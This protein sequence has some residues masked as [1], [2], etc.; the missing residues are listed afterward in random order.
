MAHNV[1]YRYNQ[2]YYTYV[3]P[4][5]QNIST[6]ACHRKIGNRL[7]YVIVFSHTLWCWTLIM[8]SST[9]VSQ[10]HC[11][12]NNILLIKCFI[13]NH[14]IAIVSVSYSL[15]NRSLDS[16]CINHKLQRLLYRSLVKD[17]RSMGWVIW[18]MVTSQFKTDAFFQR[19][20]YQ[21]T[22]RATWEWCSN[23]ANKLFFVDYCSS[24][25]A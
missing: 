4:D 18:W 3:G 7:K 25:D 11:R 12:I 24:S 5:G 14:N 16:R 19:G 15:I 6:M 8:P 2:F 21:A 23:L 17:L 13:C 1:V 10:G 22:L 9:F 20:W